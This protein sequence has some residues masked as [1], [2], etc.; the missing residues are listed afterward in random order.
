MPVLSE[1]TAYL[2]HAKSNGAWEF[3]YPDPNNGGPITAQ[4]AVVFVRVTYTERDGNKTVQEFQC[5]GDAFIYSQQIETFWEAVHAA[6]E[7]D[8]VV[9]VVCYR[10]VLDLMNQQIG[11]YGKGYLP[12]ELKKAMNENEGYLNIELTVWV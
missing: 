2:A 9:K 6:N 12:R 11:T 3:M 5:L 8:E 10:E 7:C 4:T 1:A